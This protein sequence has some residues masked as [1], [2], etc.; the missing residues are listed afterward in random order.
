MSF[1]PVLFA[2]GFSGRC[3]TP[4]PLMMRSIGLL[5]RTRGVPHPESDDAPSAVRRQPGHNLL[6]F[7]REPC[8]CRGLFFTSA[9]P[10]LSRR[11]STM[12][13]SSGDRKRQNRTELLDRPIRILGLPY[14]HQ[15]LLAFERLSTRIAFHTANRR[16]NGRL[17]GSS[18]VSNATLGH[19]DL[20]A[21][22]KHTFF[23]QFAS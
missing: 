13:A 4:A 19:T 22:F 11:A 9:M 2:R 7:D 3:S 20:G 14:L 15:A 16:K 10:T 8:L 6:G 21:T 12:N 18:C 23:F 5:I 17:R 1:R